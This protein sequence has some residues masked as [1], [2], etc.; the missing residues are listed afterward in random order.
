V[1]APKYRVEGAA[2]LARTLR[3]AS[4]NV[5]DLV[6]V[7]TEVGQIVAK[8]GEQW[9]PRETGT[10]AGTIRSTGTKAEANVRAGSTT[11]PYAGV[12]EFGWPERRIPASPY[13]TRSL[14]TNEPAIVRTYEDAVDRVLAR[15][16]GV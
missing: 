13:L 9:V 2:E 15:V 3:S 7:H 14:E 4:D 16:H 1:A 10:L 11:V 8:G 5:E 6:E 12:Q